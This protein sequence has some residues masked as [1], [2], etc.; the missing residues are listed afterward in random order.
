VRRHFFTQKPR[1]GGAS[2]FLGLKTL[3]AGA[4]DCF[5]LLEQTTDG[6]DGIRGLVHVLLALRMGVHLC[7]SVVVGITAAFVGLRQRRLEGCRAQGVTLG[8]GRV[9]VGL[10]VADL[11]LAGGVIRVEGVAI[12]VAGAVQ[13]R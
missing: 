11:L 2:A 10:K 4:S 7:L 6:I 9:Y 3:D 5:F 12:A 1:S 8:I 13:G